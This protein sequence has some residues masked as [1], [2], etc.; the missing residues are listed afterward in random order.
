MFHY[1]GRRW[2]LLPG[3]LDSHG[4]LSLRLTLKKKVNLPPQVNQCRPEGQSPTDLCTALGLILG[5]A[6]CHLV[7]STAMPCSYFQSHYIV[8]TSKNKLIYPACRALHN[9]FLTFQIITSSLCHLPFSSRKQGYQLCPTGVRHIFSSTQLPEL[10]FL[11]GMS[12]LKSLPTEF[13][14]P[15]FK[16]QPTQ[17]LHE[18]HNNLFQAQVAFSSF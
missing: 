13:F 4:L 16:V 1:L 11:P 8:C 17:H 15:L 5:H 10:S 18:V 6:W 9:P 2:G 14:Y 3:Y 7:L 12:S